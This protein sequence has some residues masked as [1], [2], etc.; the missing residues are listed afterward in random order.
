MITTANGETGSRE[1]LGQRI[2][3]QTGRISK[4]RLQSENAITSSLFS[5]VFCSRCS[6]LKTFAG[7][8]LRLGFL[9]LSRFRTT[10]AT[11]GQLG[12]AMGLSICPT[13]QVFYCVTVLNICVLNIHQ[14]T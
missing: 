9:L 14:N 8:V 10:L 11:E 2:Q 12:E 1:V 6:V 13:T 5:G 4:Q 3:S 7:S